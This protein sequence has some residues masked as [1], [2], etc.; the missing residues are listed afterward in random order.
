M[1][2]RELLGMVIEEQK[3]RILER[4]EGLERNL[5]G[6]ILRH[7]D[8]KEVVVISGIRRAGKSTLLVQIIKRLLKNTGKDNIFY[9]NLEDERLEGFGLKDFNT[10]WELF[11]EINNP[12]G[13]AYVFLDEIQEVGKWEKWVNRLYETENAKIFITGSNARL[14]SSEISSLLTGRN[15]TYNL[16]P[17]SFSEVF[18]DG[19]T[20]DTRKRAE[21]NRALKRYFEFGGFPE[22]FLKG[23]RIL[24]GGYLRDIVN[25]D[26]ISRY[27]IRNVKL[28]NEFVRY[29]I[30]C[31]GRGVTFGRLK[32]VFNLG[33]VNTAKKYLGFMEEAYLVYAVESYSSSTS[34]VVKSPRKVYAADHSLAEYMS[35]KVSPNPG[36]GM[37]NIVFL[38]LK[39]R[40]NTNPEMGIYYWKDEGEVDFLVKDG[41]KIKELI[42]VCRDIEDPETK[43]RETRPLLKAMEKF[44][45]REGTVITGD[46][47][48]LETV[49]GRKIRYVPLWKWILDNR[50]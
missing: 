3:A 2:N 25:R 11:L 15:I 50:S 48:L 28:F 13:R 9:I 47:E 18:R 4:D 14:L 5:L 7:L 38:E 22:V 35:L 19:K 26:I 41:L 49:K 10:L 24:L 32:G 46:F 34:E 37:E 20:Y 40:Q 39:R 36:Q 8:L 42:Q 1:L 12:K 33:S 31:Y 16:L 29:L 27:K 43:K 45:L 6:V 17:F 30:S 21:M 44:R 23:D